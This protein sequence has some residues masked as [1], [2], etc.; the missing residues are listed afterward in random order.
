[1]ILPATP[2]LQAIKGLLG[3]GLNQR[4]YLARPE[5]PTVWQKISTPEARVEDFL[6][7]HDKLVVLDKS[8]I[9]MADLVANP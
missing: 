3:F 1:M 6:F 7:W 9:H 8:G 2:N 5:T 4:L